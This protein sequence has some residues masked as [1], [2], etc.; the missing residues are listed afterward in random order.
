MSRA[1]D[2][3]TAL[4]A[5]VRADPPLRRLFGLEPDRAAR[6]TF[7]ACGLALDLSKQPWSAASFARNSAASRPKI[8]TSSAAYSS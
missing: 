7:E 4:E 6:L 2:A 8:R 3:W 1:A 5:A